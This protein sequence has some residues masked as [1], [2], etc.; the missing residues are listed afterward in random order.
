MLQ[1]AP[2]KRSL[3][4]DLGGGTRNDE[5]YIE[6]VA[7]RISGIGTDERGRPS[8]SSLL[9]LHLITQSPWS[10]YSIG[11][12]GWKITF[13]NSNVKDD[14]AHRG[15]NFQTDSIIDANE[16][17]ILLDNQKALGYDGTSQIM[18]GWLKSALTPCRV[19]ARNQR[20]EFY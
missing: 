6:R 15:K 1:P 10:I 11:C 12:S 2:L 16:D 18:M 4:R 5:R 19:L 9:V 13:S 20:Y 14:I 3:T 8:L 7:R 17:N